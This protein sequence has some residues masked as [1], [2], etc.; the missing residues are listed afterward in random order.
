MI[1]QKTTPHPEARKLLSL[2]KGGEGDGL[3]L[4]T[5]KPR[6]KTGALDTSDNAGYQN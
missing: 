3:C 5:K 1:E 6:S 4:P 2:A